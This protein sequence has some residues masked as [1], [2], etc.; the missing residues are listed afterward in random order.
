MFLSSDFTQSV[1]SLGNSIFTGPIV[2]VVK[3]YRLSWQSKLKYYPRKPPGSALS[4]RFGNSVDYSNLISF[5]SHLR[6]CCPKRMIGC[7]LLKL[8]YKLCLKLWLHSSI[9][10]FT[11]HWMRQSGFN[12]LAPDWLPFAC[13]MHARACNINYHFICRCLVAWMPSI[14][15]RTR[16]SN[17]CDNVG[18]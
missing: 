15:L 10:L 16:L 3:P 4:R 9:P 5:V 11:F 18:R 12:S 1:P 8:M 2:V 17:N 6:F 14:C 13:H 7:L